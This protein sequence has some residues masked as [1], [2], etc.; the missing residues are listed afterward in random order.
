MSTS[1]TGDATQSAQAAP[2]DPPT[3]QTIPAP[4]VSNSSADASSAAATVSD[5]SGRTTKWIGPSLT[6]SDGVYNP[7]SLLEPDKNDDATAT[8]LEHTRQ[9]FDLTPKSIAEDLANLRQDIK[10]L[11]IAFAR[12]RDL[13]QAEEDKRHGGFFA[14]KRA[15]A[16]LDA[17]QVAALNLED[18]EAAAQTSVPR[19]MAILQHAEVLVKSYS[20]EQSTKNPEEFLSLYHAK[21]KIVELERAIE[22]LKEKNA[23]LQK[24]LE[25]KETALKLAAAVAS[26]DKPTDGP[27]AAN[28]APSAIDTPPVSPPGTPESP[29]SQSSLKRISGGVQSLVSTFR[30]GLVGSRSASPAAIAEDPA[31]AKEVKIETGAEAPAPS[32][33]LT[34]VVET[35]EDDKSAFISATGE[36]FESEH[37]YDFFISYRVATDSKVAMELYFR[38][39]DQRVVDE[40]GQSRHVRVYW[41][42]EC[43][44]KGQDWHDGFVDGLKNSRCVLMLVSPGAIEM[45][46]KS[47]SGADNVLLEWETCIAA[48]QKDICVPQPLFINDPKRSVSA[49]EA[50]LNFKNSERCPKVRPLIDGAHK[51]SAFTTLQTVSKLQAIDVDVNEVS[52]SIPD[53]IKALESFRSVQSKAAAEQCT[54]EASFFNHFPL[55]KFGEMQ[56]TLTFLTESDLKEVFGFNG[57]EEKKDGILKYVE[58]DWEDLRLT[59]NDLPSI[60]D[61]SMMILSTGLAKSYP[62]LTEINLKNARVNDMHIWTTF[63]GA[64]KENTQL[65]TLNLTAND[66]LD[67]PNLF[68][69]IAAHPKL[70][71]VRVGSGFDPLPFLKGQVVTYASFNTINS[72]GLKILAKVSSYKTPEVQTISISA[73]ED[74]QDDSAIDAFVTFLTTVRGVTYVTVP[75][76]LVKGVTNCLLGST[77]L[78]NITITGTGVRP[79][80]SAKKDEP[81]VKSSGQ[82][83]DK[84]A[85]KKTLSSAKKG[86]DWPKDFCDA[87]VN[88]AIK[89]STT[90]DGVVESKVEESSPAAAQPESTTANPPT[91][92]QEAKESTEGGNT[93][94]ENA[95]DAA[96]E[97]IPQF[98]SLTLD[99]LYLSDEDVE[100]IA[101]ALTNICGIAVTNL[102]LK[103]NEITA[104]GASSLLNSFEA[105][106]GNS[107]I[108]TIDLSCNMIGPSAKN[109]LNN[110]IK[111][112]PKLAYLYLAENPLGEAV[113]G[114]AN[115]IQVSR[116]TTSL[117]S[118]DLRRTNITGDITAI[119][120]MIGSN[121]T[122]T[123]LD[124][125][126][127][128]ISEDGLSE[129]GSRL[130]GNEVLAD[131]NFND[132]LSGPKGLEDLTEA[133]KNEK[134][135]IYRLCLNNCQLGDTGARLVFESRK[136]RK[137]TTYIYLE[138]ND[139]KGTPELCDVL[140]KNVDLLEGI[141]YLALSSNPLSPQ[142]MESFAKVLVRTSDKKRT[143][144]WE[145]TVKSREEAA[146]QAKKDAEEAKAAAEEAKKQAGGDGQAADEAAAGAPA[147]EPA[148]PAN[149]DEPSEY[150]P[151]SIDDVIPSILSLDLIGCTNIEEGLAK[152]FEVLPQLGY[153]W[154]DI[155]NTPFSP[156]IVKPLLPAISNPK[157]RFRLYMEGSKIGDSGYEE[158][159]T[160]ISALNPDDVKISISLDSMFSSFSSSVLIKT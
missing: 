17:E 158:L 153:I 34:P 107:L 110:F 92:T 137:N 15:A 132:S 98:Q 102:S 78:I 37:T 71:E 86:Q 150:N 42:K 31:K 13:R 41:D 130:A 138:S 128:S 133:L 87:L 43:L 47:H 88:R 67:V 117:V 19:Y 54:A 122:I 157:S 3:D 127:N 46:A 6:H 101:R 90:V 69:N 77:T 112:A 151:K 61:T 75:V 111:H 57:K 148:T 18:K 2:A 38:L 94:T 143:D 119:A 81:D 12:K 80:A 68:E 126:E 55:A 160:A 155:R 97:S 30:S 154:L 141:A 70:S 16:G 136:E 96:P 29:Q 134:C 4:S 24:S 26:N 89:A 60:S 9:L 146:E 115:A 82:K 100:H 58:H 48:G 5:N 10:V 22:N 109:A 152:I 149:D 140:D 116:K 95:P 142:L 104:A 25:E 44:K 59:F 33:A 118:L 32:V 121:H 135:A 35:A 52:W 45:M 113:D 28:A 63:A 129:F 91:N 79:N 1:S 106:K 84:E 131:L 8:F 72:L 11:A 105:G 108:Q 125:S 65:T 74:D 23:D 124:L 40:F 53:C 123:T 27:V 56:Q 103:D 7:M 36:W 147:E 139:I 93:S 145:A 85:K 120:S 83:S 66:I 73:Y 14:S 156:K 39:K 144:D 114:V 99:S 20:A 51:M 49:I 64:L 62:F 159:H 21:T 76:T 50:L